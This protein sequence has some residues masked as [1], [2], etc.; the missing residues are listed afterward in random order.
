M[1]KQSYNMKLKVIT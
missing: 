1:A